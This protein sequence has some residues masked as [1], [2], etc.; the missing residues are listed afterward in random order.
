MLSIV[1]YCFICTDFDFIYE[2]GT[3]ADDKAKSNPNFVKVCGFALDYN[4]N[5]VSCYFMEDFSVFDLSKE[6]LAKSLKDHAIF[7]GLGSISNDKQF[8]K[9][10]NL[11]SYKIYGS[12]DFSDIIDFD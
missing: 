9:R 5:P 12:Y 6:D 1:K 2:K 7:K 3:S 10:I 11:D 8:R 4:F